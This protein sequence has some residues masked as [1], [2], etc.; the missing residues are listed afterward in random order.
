MHIG[1]IAL[2]A[3]VSRNFNVYTAKELQVF[4]NKL[5]NAP[6]YVEHVAVEN[7]AEKVTKC[8]YDPASRCL[9]YEAEIYDQTIQ[10]NPQR[11]HPAR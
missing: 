1:G 3:G 7:A 11:T 8:T 9:L 10:Q 2:V 4:A 6:V 5:V